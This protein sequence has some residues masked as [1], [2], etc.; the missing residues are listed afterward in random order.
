[1][2][3]FGDSLQQ[4]SSDLQPPVQVY[5]RSP[6]KGLFSFVPMGIPSYP[7]K[8][9]IT[10]QWWMTEHLYLLNSREGCKK[11]EKEHLVNFK[12]LVLVKF[13][14]VANLLILTTYF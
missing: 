1:M 14:M 11:G 7:F 4:G 8:V 13:Y 5:I 3:I 10:M 9:I 6:E 12:S 2:K